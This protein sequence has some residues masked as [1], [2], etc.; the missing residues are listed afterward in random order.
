MRHFLLSRVKVGP[1]I[2]N[3]LETVQ[4]I[5][6]HTQEVA[7]ELSIG[8]EFDDLQLQWSRT[9]RNGRYLHYFTEIGIFRGHL[10]HRGW[11]KA[12]R[13]WRRKFKLCK[14]VRPC[15]H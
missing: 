1:I 9:R 13:T 12:P 5:I 6:I 11:S 7:Y 15:Q 2:H 10:S 4:V 8:T 3:I 14:I